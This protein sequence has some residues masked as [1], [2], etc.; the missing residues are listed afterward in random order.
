WGG[1]DGEP[2]AL[3]PSQP[4]RLKPDAE[5]IHVLY[6]AVADLGLKWLVPE[7][8][9][10]G[11]LDEWF[12]PGRRQQ[13]FCPGFSSSAPGRRSGTLTRPQVVLDPEPPKPS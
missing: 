9:A 4:A 3:P 12:L 2:E 13:S 10:H 6:K 5:L 8:P 1:S 11:L 7:K